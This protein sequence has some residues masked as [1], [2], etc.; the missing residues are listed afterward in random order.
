MSLSRTQFLRKPV[1]NMAYRLKRGIHNSLSVQH[2][3]CGC[4]GPLASCSLARFTDDQFSLFLMVAE[5]ICDSLLCVCVGG[6]G[7]R[8][9]SSTSEPSSLPFFSILIWT[10]IT[11]LSRPQLARKKILCPSC[12]WVNRSWHGHLSPKVQFRAQGEV[13]H[14]HPV[15][16][17]D[18]ALGEGLGGGD[19][20]SY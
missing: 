3:W 19:A 16:N 4:Q 15:A 7:C 20:K 5:L 2:L 17:Q 11:S 18:S 8:F 10:Q 9:L 1:R 13:G 14:Q 12:K 6:G